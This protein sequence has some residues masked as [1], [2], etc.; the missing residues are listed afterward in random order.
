MTKFAVGQQVRVPIPGEVKD[1]I[2]QVAGYQNG[3][4]AEVM[5]ACIIVQFAEGWSAIHP[6][7]VCG[8]D[9]E[10]TPPAAQQTE[11][12]LTNEWAQATPKERGL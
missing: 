2:R 6:Q 1:G 7:M 10:F 8:M 5:A 4:V 11:Q 3:T 12:E 9:E